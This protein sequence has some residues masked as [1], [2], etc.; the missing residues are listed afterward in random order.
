MKKSLLALAVLAVATS[1]TA[2]T[3]YD[4]DGTSLKVG[5][6]VQAVAFN[7]NFGK[8][9]RDDASLKNSARFNVA[10]TTKVNDAVSVFAF[11]EWEASNGNNEKDADNDFTARDQYV[12][13]D[14]GVF[15]KVQAGKS[16]NAIYDVQSATD[17]FEEV[18]SAQVQGDTNGDRRSGTF[19]YIYDN[20][21]LYASA[22][23]QTAQDQVK[24]AGDKLDVENGFGFGLGYTFDNVVFGPLSVKAAYDYVKCQDDSDFIQT[25]E[26]GDKIQ[27]MDPVTNDFIPAGRAFDS[28]KNTAVSVAWGSDTGLYFAALYNVYKATFDNYTDDD[29]IY[30]TNPRAKVKGAELVA[31][32]GFDNGLSLTIGYHFKDEKEKYTGWTSSSSIQRRVPVIANYQVAPTFKVWVEAEFDANSSDDVNNDKKTHNN[33]DTL[34][35]AGARY[36]F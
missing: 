9:G 2:A 5:G 28:F 23:F 31:G 19:R 33:K 34:F 25:D 17:V 16:L 20:N 6:R 1:A 22:S 10:G 32:Y 7:G 13:A 36:V 29:G 4:K 26:D 14:F 21:G 30:K 8:A 15:G 18:G 11:T 12:G 27:V 35:A 3:V 24:V